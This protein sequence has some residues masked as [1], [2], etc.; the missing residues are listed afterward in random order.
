MIV[1]CFHELYPEYPSNTC[2]LVD[3]SVN[4]GDDLVLKFEED[5]EFRIAV[6]VDM[7]DTGVD[8]LA[9]LNLVFFKKVRSKIKFVR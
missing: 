8:V 5:N 2:Q 3:Y 6:S 7:L 4:Y 1:D 9:V